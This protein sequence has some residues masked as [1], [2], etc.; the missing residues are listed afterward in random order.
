MRDLDLPVFTNNLFC[1]LTANFTGK[2]VPLNWEH[3]HN[4]CLMS[5]R[6]YFRFDK[7][8]PEF[9][10]PLSPRE[11]VVPTE[12]PK[13]TKSDAKAAVAAAIA[14]A[15]HDHS[16][17]PHIDVAELLGETKLVDDRR[18]VLQEVREHLDLL[19]EFEGV[20]TD[21]ELAKRKRDLFA[22]L[23]P[24]PPVPPGSPSASLPSSK[25]AKTEQTD[26]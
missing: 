1:V 14:A 3:A 12:R 23:P 19:K 11:V 4:H 16:G 6:L 17:E 5:Y 8:D 22:A 18:K 20:I 26:V 2:P 15:G 13:S 9:P 10:V 25:K 21:E 24:A 7:F